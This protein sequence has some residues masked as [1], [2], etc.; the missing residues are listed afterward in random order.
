MPVTCRQPA[1]CCPARGECRT[2]ANASATDKISDF[3]PGRSGHPAPLRSAILLH[4]V[5]RLVSLAPSLSGQDRRTRRQ[6]PDGVQ[7]TSNDRFK[8][9]QPPFGGWTS[10]SQSSG[11]VSSI[12]FSAA[13]AVEVFQVYHLVLFSFSPCANVFVCI[14]PD[15]ASGFPRAGRSTHRLL[16][17]QLGNYLRCLV[18]L[19]LLLLLLHL[20]PPHLIVGRT[21]HVLPSPSRS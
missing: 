3:R 8:W 21:N 14:R 19:F 18:S 4:S 12:V 7:P 13:A 2:G 16:I 17:K 15:C 10:P 11:L 20:L 9:E 5:G 1:G 6:S